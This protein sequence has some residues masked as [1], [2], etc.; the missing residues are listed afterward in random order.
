MWDTNC[1]YYN[2]ARHAMWQ[3]DWEYVTRD[4]LI[5]KYGLNK[6]DIM[7]IPASNNYFKGSNRITY[8]NWLRREDGQELIKLVRHQQRKWRACYRVTDNG[9]NTRVEKENIKIDEAVLN[10]TDEQY[11]NDFAMKKVY[12]VDCEEYNE[13]YIEVTR[14]SALVQK[15]LECYDEESKIMRGHLF[16]SNFDDGII[17]CLTSIIKDPMKAI[18]RLSMQIDTSLGKLIKNS[19]EV[20]WENLSDEDKNNWKVLS[21]KLVSGGAILRKKRGTVG[22]LVEP[23]NSG[24][25]PPE[26]FTVWQYWVSV[27]EDVMGGRNAQG[28]KE[29]NSSNESGVLFEKR[30]EA[31]FAM[32]YLYMYN[33]GRA[34]KGLGE[35]IYEDI[36]AIY[37]D[38]EE[39]VLEITDSDLDEEVMKA[40]QEANMYQESKIRKGRGYLKLSKQHLDFGKA[41]ARI[42]IEKGAHSASAKE[43]KMNMWLTIN[44]LR[45]EAGQQPYPVEIWADSLEIDATVRN[46]MKEFEK[47]E[48]QKAAEAAQMNKMKMVFDAQN[49]GMGNLQKGYGDL[50]NAEVAGKEK[51]ASPEGAMA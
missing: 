35:G 10:Y 30:M 9:G 15:E 32:A 19:Y 13:E 3:E 24:N 51:A 16:A 8:E 46:K 34:M 6:D 48:A 42:I 43:R 22:R 39:R 7:S 17:W 37:G 29:R 11:V 2:I 45:I 49:Q 1:K 31:G 40:F 38:S 14:F 26:L 28:L 36:Q 20:D 25:I 21:Q 12:D 47:Q 4:E 5:N 44:K 41:K 50:H 33:L 23:V 27:L 18:D